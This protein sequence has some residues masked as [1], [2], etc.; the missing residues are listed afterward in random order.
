MLNMNRDPGASLL[1]D[2]HGRNSANY[3]IVV[4]IEEDSGRQSDS[5]PANLAISLDVLPERALL[6]GLLLTRWRPCACAVHLRDLLSSRIA[7]FLLRALTCLIIDCRHLVVWI[8]GLAKNPQQS[9]T[10]KE[11]IINGTGLGTAD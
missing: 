7:G 5:N 10:D 2:G 4:A 9:R 8:S 6:I 3:N 1:E 11:L